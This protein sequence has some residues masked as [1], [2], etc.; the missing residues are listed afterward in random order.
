MSDAVTHKCNKAVSFDFR[1]KRQSLQ[2]L[3]SSPH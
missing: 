1:R 3:L 2:V